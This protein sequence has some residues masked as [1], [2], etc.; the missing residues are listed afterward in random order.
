M[1]DRL[2]VFL[3]RPLRDADRPR[4]FALAV[5]LILGAAALF[6]LLD[7]AGSAPAPRPAP[8]PTDRSFD[9]PEPEPAPR[10]VA[11]VKR[12]ARRFLAGYLP[13]S[14]GR[15][16]AADIEAVAPE[17][18]RQLA[19]ERPRVPRSVARRRPRVVLLQAEGAG[20]TALVSD[21]RRRY[22]VELT[23]EDGRVVDV[24]G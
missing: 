13:Y 8:T 18:R 11:Q 4:L 14:Y 10:D 19:S 20:V 9:P 16:D 17:L 2:R 22:A 7:D 15:G 12:A 24:G 6:A 1:I 21:G 5:G 3:N 23:V